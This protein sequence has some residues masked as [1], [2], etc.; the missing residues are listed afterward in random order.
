MQ[1]G[2]SR[3]AFGRTAQAAV[4]CELSATHCIT[5]RFA[6]RLHRLHDNKRV[7]RIYDYADLEVPMLARMYKKRLEGYRAIGYSVQDAEN[8][9]E[10]P[11][12]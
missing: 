11:P 6:G 7:V 3:R 2:A 1:H 8:T 4:K 5:H 10:P 9:T 12:F